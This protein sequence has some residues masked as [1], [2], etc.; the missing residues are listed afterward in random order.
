LYS[1]EL[2]LGIIALA[3]E[4]NLVI[5]ADEV[6][7]KVLYDDVKHTAMGSLSDDVLTLTFN[8]LSKKLSLLWL[9]SWLDGGLR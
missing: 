8:S 1:N 7:D 9:Q 3:R 2:L 4:F 6:Y 5:F